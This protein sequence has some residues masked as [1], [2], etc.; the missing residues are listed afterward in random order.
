M[1]AHGYVDVEG[2]LLR[3]VRELVGPSTVVAAELDP[4]SHLTEARL[5]NADIL[6]AYKEFP[7]IDVIE[8][9]EELVE[10]TLR[11]L[12]GEINPVM[13]AFDCRMIEVL[14]T[15]TEPMRSFVDRMMQLEPHSNLSDLTKLEA[16]SQTPGTDPSILSVS[17]IHGFMAADVPAVGSSMLVVTDN[18]P[19]AGCAL[20]KQL[21]MELFEF[22]GV[23]R[24]RYLAP[25]EA[26]ASATALPATGR[27]VVIADVWDNPGGGTA[28]DGTV[29]LNTLL[30]AGATNVG[31]SSIWDPQAVELCG[32][33]GAGAKLQVCIDCD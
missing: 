31:Y 32:A 4:H 23:T 2:D 12:R 7:H 28:G 8:R 26:V 20:A 13:S 24:P 1:V 19:A 9:A 33:A 30:D 11:T 10:L 18:N 14:P 25:D 3:S 16:H 29:L 15:S 5:E 17:C 21:G 27:P 22:R 6:I